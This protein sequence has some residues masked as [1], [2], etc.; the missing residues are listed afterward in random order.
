MSK[1]GATAGVLKL[2]ITVGPALEVF[3][4]PGVFVL[5]CPLQKVENIK[6]LKSNILF[7][8]V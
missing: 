2:L 1:S 8:E 3:G 6:K 4:V 7:K 5:T